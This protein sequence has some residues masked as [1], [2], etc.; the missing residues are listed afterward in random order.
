M[1]LSAAILVVALLAAGVILFL[2]GR[3]AR[4]DLDAVRRVATDLRE[5][6]VEGRALSPE[7]AERAIAA[8]EPLL[9]DREA[10]A[11]HLDELAGIA[12]SAAAWAQAAPAP[13]WELRVAVALRGAADDLR[14]WAVRGDERRRARA[15]SRLS[16]A[17]RALEARRTGEPPAGGATRG[18]QDRLDNL[19]HAA[20]EQMQEL[21]EALR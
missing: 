10:A 13:S 2:Q 4:E 12:A 8:L 18:I 7:D 9:S 15:R 16:E 1:R 19:Q 21:D 5:R 6:G 11:V 20:D 17:R 14:S 3:S